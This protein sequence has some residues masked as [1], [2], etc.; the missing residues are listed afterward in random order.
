MFSELRRVIGAFHMAVGA[1]LLGVGDD[2]AEDV[3]GEVE[4]ENEFA[5]S[6]NNVMPGFNAD[7]WDRFYHFQGGRLDGKFMRSYGFMTI[8][9]LGTASGPVRVVYTHDYMR[10]VATF[11]HEETIVA[12]GSL[13]DGSE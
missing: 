3:V 10:G 9:E 11:Y 6:A 8:L 12:P 2:S 4:Q 7:H 1:T 13:G 5:Q